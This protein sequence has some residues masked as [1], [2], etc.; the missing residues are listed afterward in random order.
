MGIAAVGFHIARVEGVD[1][2][3]HQPGKIRLE[4]PDNADEDITGKLG[5]E[6]AGDLGIDGF[7]NGKVTKAEPVVNEYAENARCFHRRR[8]RQASR[9]IRRRAPAK[10]T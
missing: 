3:L 8:R 10:P 7:H 5:G 2:L 9:G 4:G 1:H 6:L